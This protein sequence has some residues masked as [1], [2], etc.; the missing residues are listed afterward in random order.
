MTTEESLKS[1]W[2]VAAIEALKDVLERIGI[3]LNNAPF[4]MYDAETA[5]VYPDKTRIKIGF[6]FFYGDKIVGI[7]DERDYSGLIDQTANLYLTYTTLAATLVDTP[8]W[9]HAS[10]PFNEMSDSIASILTKLKN[11]A[12]MS[13]TDMIKVAINECRRYTGISAK[14]VELNPTEFLYYENTDKNKYV[15][16]VAKESIR[17]YA[18]RLLT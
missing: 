4:S 1:K 5:I 11:C 7:M 14:D 2:R 9:A 15:P 6:N 8:T 17:E 12:V 13:K 10:E 16:T 18:R 3:K